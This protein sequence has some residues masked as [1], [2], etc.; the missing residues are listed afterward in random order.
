[1]K[2][3]NQSIALP[4][5]IKIAKIINWATQNPIEKIERI[6]PYSDLNIAQSQ[7]A[8]KDDDFY[9]ELTE[10]KQL[11]SSQHFYAIHHRSATIYR[12]VFAGFS[13]L[14]F[15]LMLALVYQKASGFSL[16][17]S[18]NCATA[19]TWLSIISGFI[20]AASFA[21][22]LHIRTEREAVSYIQR[23]AKR[24][25]TQMYFRKGVRFGWRRFI[26]FMPEYTEFAVVRIAY[27][28]ALDKMREVKET[29][30]VI[31]DQVANA[32]HFTAAEKGR[33]F[34]QGILELR[35]KLNVS[36][37]TFNTSV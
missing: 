36:I 20:S 21:I 11:T 17:F 30:L 19:K 13:A 7:D 5:Q 16:L 8:N 35:D 22:G 26:F 2:S 9:P 3:D 28:D 37:H 15:L 23:R 1:M 18:G 10:F 14:F 29:T 25:L 12:I 27:R 33:L 32:R 31:L 6:D 34:N 24:R 4:K